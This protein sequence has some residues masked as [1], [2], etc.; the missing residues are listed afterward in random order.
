[1][2]ERCVRGAALVVLDRLFLCGCCGWGYPAIVMISRPFFQ[3]RRFVESF[4]PHVPDGESSARLCFVPVIV[5]N[6]QKQRPENLSS[7]IRFGKREG[8]A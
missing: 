2:P 1:M 8:S 4:L 5:T 3:T 7:E 6:H